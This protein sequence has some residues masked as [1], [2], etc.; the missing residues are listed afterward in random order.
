MHPAHLHLLYLIG[1]V[2]AV[3]EAVPDQSAV[4]APTIIASPEARR[5]IRTPPTLC[6]VSGGREVLQS[7][8]GVPA[9]HSWSDMAGSVEASEPGGAVPHLPRKLVAALPKSTNKTSVLRVRRLCS[10][11]APPDPR[12]CR[13]HSGA[14]RHTR[15]HWSHTSHRHIATQPRPSPRDGSLC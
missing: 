12:R 3:R 1:A 7:A 8:D 6:L 15:G 4:D 5:M 10:P 11:D 9:L 14:P 13:R 2:S